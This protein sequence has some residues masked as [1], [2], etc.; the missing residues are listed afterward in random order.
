MKSR[1]QRICLRAV[2]ASQE[3]CIPPTFKNSSSIF[4]GNDIVGVFMTKM[5]LI[6]KKESTN[7]ASLH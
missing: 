5:Y 7:M 6:K 2:R 4:L 3:T 1:K